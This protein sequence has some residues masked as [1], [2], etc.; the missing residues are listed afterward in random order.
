MVQ[1]A[2]EPSCVLSTQDLAL[3]PYVWT[4]P[5]QTTRVPV[6]SVSCS[7]DTPQDVMIN[8]ALSLGVGTPRALTGPGGALAYTVTISADGTSFEQPWGDG[9]AGTVT[10]TRTLN[11]LSLPQVD[12]LPAVTIL[13]GQQLASGSYS[14]TLTVTLTLM[15][16]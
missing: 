9:S 14:D 6:A 3:P 15:A 16:P 5:A 13:P 11:T 12:L 4:D 2:S 7:A 10:W 1:A 8:A